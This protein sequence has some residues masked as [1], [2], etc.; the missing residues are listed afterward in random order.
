[1]SNGEDLGKVD[2]K[3]EIFQADSLS[4]PLFVLSMVL[5]PLIPRNVN[6]SYKWGKNNIG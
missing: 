1:M 3:R 4:P 2:V 5:L 6:A